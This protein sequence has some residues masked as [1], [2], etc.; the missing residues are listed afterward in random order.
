MRRWAAFQRLGFASALLAGGCGG[1]GKARTDGG[2][3]NGGVTAASLGLTPCRDLSPGAVS[4]VAAAGG[5][6]FSG[7]RRAGRIRHVRRRLGDSP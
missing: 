4:I 1:S 6:Y 7:D 2:A 3:G 5:G